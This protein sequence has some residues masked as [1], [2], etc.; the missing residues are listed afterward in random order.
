MH[1][2]REGFAGIPG[3]LV[4]SRSAYHQAHQ[5]QVSFASL[6]SF[7]SSLASFSADSFRKLF[8]PRVSS[9]LTSYNGSKPLCAS[10]PSLCASAFP[11]VSPPF[12]GRW[13]AYPE[14]A[15]N[16]E[17]E[18]LQ[19]VLISGSGSLIPLSF[20][21]IC[22]WLMCHYPSRLQNGDTKFT[23]RSNTP[24]TSQRGGVVFA[25][26]LFGRLPQT[27]LGPDKELAEDGR[28]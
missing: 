24:R 26:T 13:Q 18:H 11:R 5:I 21:A 6:R 15:C 3:P 22:F 20:L 14:I 8:C 12:R 2:T 23:R 27:L 10:V 9:L 16:W 7:P 25:G 28:G 1:W 19:M 4:R 17:D